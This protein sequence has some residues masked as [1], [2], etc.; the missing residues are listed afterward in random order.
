MRATVRRLFDHSFAEGTEWFLP[1]CRLQQRASTADVGTD[2]FVRAHLFGHDMLGECALTEVLVEE[3]AR[4]PLRERS[5]A[6]PRFD[7]WKQ[8]WPTTTL[9][10]LR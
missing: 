10:S 9:R 5:A 6:L 7:A 4:D 2:R 1:R 8:T 3:P